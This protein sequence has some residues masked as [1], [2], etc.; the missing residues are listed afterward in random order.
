[1][2]LNNKDV[3]K[4]LYH[5][6]IYELCQQSL[7]FH[8]LTHYSILWNKTLN[9]TELEQYCDKNELINFLTILIKKIK[10]KLPFNIQIIDIDYKT[11]I[12]DYTQRKSSS[13]SIIGSLCKDLKTN[14]GYTFEKIKKFS[15]DYELKFL[16]EQYFNTIKVRHGL[17]NN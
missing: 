1:M 10:D 16:S 7:Q 15:S 17:I 9:T 13:Y 11:L 12:S 8:D 14:N 5:T 6:I 3:K 2:K 4:L